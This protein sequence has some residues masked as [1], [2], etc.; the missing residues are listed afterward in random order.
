M[1]SSQTRTDKSYKSIPP[2]RISAW[3][4]QRFKF[5]T[6]KNGT[7]YTICNPFDGDTGYNFNI[8]PLKGTCHDWRDNTWAGPVSPKT[9][10]R[11]CSFINF[12]MIYLKCNYKQALQNILGSGVN[13]AGY[14]KSK[15]KEEA[16]KEELDITLPAGSLPLSSSAGKLASLLIGWLKGRG[17]TTEDIKKYDLW[18]S[19]SN[20]VWPYYEFEQLV[21]YQSRS[22][23]NKVFRFPDVELGKKTDFLYGFDYAEPASY[24][25]ITESIFGAYTLGEQALATGGA[26]LDERQVR[27]IKLLGPQ[28]WLILAPDN[29][30]AGLKSI[31][32]NSKLLQS[33]G[34]KVAYSVPPKIEYTDTDGEV[35]HTKDWNELLTGCDMSKDEIRQIMDDGIEPCSMAAISSI[36]GLI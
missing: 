9:G 17:Y 15:V 23:L 13:L 36:Y 2:E 11:N 14:L 7:E 26:I 18:H 1:E 5:K 24:L 34:Y 6:R 29:D 27:K 8:S 12:V 25:I 33:Y 21:Y 28:N 30:K 32:G 19:G 22:Y 16:V 20:V 10:K 35:K 4:E 3:I 31:I